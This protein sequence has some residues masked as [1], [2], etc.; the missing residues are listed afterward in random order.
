VVPAQPGPVRRP[1]PGTGHGGRIGFF[2]TAVWELALPAPGRRYATPG[3]DLMVASGFQGHSVPPSRSPTLRLRS[4]AAGAALAGATPPASKRQGRSWRIGSGTRPHPGPGKAVRRHGSAGGDQQHGACPLACRSSD[5]GGPVEPA[6]G[7]SDSGH[8][9]REREYPRVMRASS[10]RH[11]PPH[12]RCIGAG[13]AARRDPRSSGP[14]SPRRGESEDTGC[15][16]VGCRPIPVR[17]HSRPSPPRHP[18]ARSRPPARSPH[19]KP[20]RS[21]PA[22]AWTPYRLIS[23]ASPVVSSPE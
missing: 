21:A 3:A 7:D 11:G 22:P 9:R 2:A 15:R 17:F 14:E 23:R 19:P 12:R 18:S 16:A 1:P 4:H 6:G 8:R 5:E 13:P 20:F 10:I